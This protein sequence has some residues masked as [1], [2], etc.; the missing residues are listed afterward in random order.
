MINAHSMSDSSLESCVDS[1]IQAIADEDLI[2][3]FAVNMIA[4]KGFADFREGSSFLEQV[5]FLSGT[6]GNVFKVAT[7]SDPLT[8]RPMQ[9]RVFRQA[10]GL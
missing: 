1:G 10:V 8:Y 7:G 3:E 9:I 5:C 4:Q 6:A 2:E